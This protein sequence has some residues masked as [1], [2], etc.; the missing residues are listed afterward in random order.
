MDSWPRGSNDAPDCP[1]S[2]ARLAMS[3]S[4][5]RK[6]ARWA[7]PEAPAPATKL[8]QF[9]DAG[10]CCMSYNVDMDEG[11]VSLYSFPIYWRP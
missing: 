10:Y 3:R 5:R 7:E 6:F 8:W 11:T 4:H 9:A 2:A 1:A